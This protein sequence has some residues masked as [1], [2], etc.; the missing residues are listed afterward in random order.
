MTDRYVLVVADSLAFHG[1]TSPELLTHPGL[2]PNVLGRRLGARVDVVARLGWTARDAWWALCKD[3]LVYSVFLPRADAVV[4]AVGAG[5]HLP[6]SVPTYLRDGIAYLRPGGVRRT[7]RRLYHS[8]HPRVVRATGG[9]LRA[10]PQRATD[11]Y[12]TRCVQAV[13]HLR[14]GVPVVGIVPPP[15]DSAHHGH[16]TRLHAPAVR[17]AKAWGARTQV[18]LVDADAIVAPYL[19]AGRLN[20]DGMHWPWEAHRRVGEAFADA[21][22]AS[23]RG[24]DGGGNH[25]VS[26]RVRPI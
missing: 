24:G 22:A 16:V 13:R 21:I 18:P 10:L 14:P 15:Y 17:A 7:V 2:Y 23:W 4:L 6:A 5:D 12:L 11:A 9:R 19:A 26:G 20:P 1:P 8:A 3:P 25:P